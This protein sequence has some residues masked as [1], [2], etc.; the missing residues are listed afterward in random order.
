[1][2]VPAVFLLAVL[3]FFMSTLTPGDRVEAFL[4]LTG[5]VSEDTD[6]LNE[7][8]YINVAKSINL[9][10]PL[11]Y[12]SVTPKIYTDIYYKTLIPSKNKLTK[13]MLLKGG[14]DTCIRNYFLYLDH[15]KKD[16]KYLNDSLKMTPQIKRLSNDIYS[17]DRSESFEELQNYSFELKKFNQNIDSNYLISF[18]QN[19]DNL[20]KV[21]N[22][23]YI[24]E[25]QISSFTPNFAWYGFNN[26]FHKWFGN[27]MKFN[28]GVSIIDGQS[29]SKKIS[30]SLK[31]TLIYVL[32]AYILTFGLAIPL[33]I[34]IAYN[35]KKRI[36]KFLDLKFMA[37]YSIPLFWMATL[38]V[39]FF[40]SSEIIPIFNIFPSIGIGHISSDMSLSKQI[41]TAVP[42][43][44]L[45]AIIIAIHSGAYLST[46]IKRNMLKEMKKK[47]FIALMSRGLSRKKV[48]LKH[49][50]PNSILPLITLIVVGLPASLAGS[51]IIEVIFNIPG[52]GR[53]LYD[54]ILKFDWNV[55]YAIVLVIGVAT[56][57]SYII[58]DILYT[59]F[60]PKI[61]LS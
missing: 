14:K 49:I 6:Q 4:D 61:K 22:D 45:P 23:I 39:I 32:I 15:I 40:T 28:F 7:Q 5:T 53:L 1:M 52:M 21:I 31:W 17:I 25:P 12:F 26:Q 60:N 38:A 13:S 56:Y 41:T 54:S 36:A 48:I 50:F 43:L 10:L 59:Y 46:L 3:V 57:I 51:V 55:V 16:I 35:H 47:Y 44:I 19:I 29:V 9:D 30:K 34:Y 42:H 18:N 20:I 37:F 8:D 58:G 2:M 11:F 27:T 33:G 24:S